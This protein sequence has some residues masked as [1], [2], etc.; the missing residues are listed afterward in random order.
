MIAISASRSATEARSH[1]VLTSGADCKVRRHGVATRGPYDNG[2]GARFSA[3]RSRYQVFGAVVLA[4]RLGISASA[5]RGRASA[6][7]LLSAMRPC[8][9]QGSYASSWCAART[10]GDCT[11]DRAGISTVLRTP[12]KINYLFG[13]RCIDRHGWRKCRKLSATIPA[14]PALLLVSRPRLFPTIV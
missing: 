14:A 1:A 5:R 11:G 3:L 7:R 12:V 8:S 13:H 9:R 6:W 4:P 10:P 2:F